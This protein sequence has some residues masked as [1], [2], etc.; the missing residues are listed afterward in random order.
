MCFTLFGL[1]FSVVRVVTAELGTPWYPGAEQ[2]QTERL[3][4]ASRN[5]GHLLYELH[6]F[7]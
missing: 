5:R 7:R 2:F 6:K 3:I 4:E 1:T